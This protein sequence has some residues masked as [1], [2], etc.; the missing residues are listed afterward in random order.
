MFPTWP[1]KSELGHRAARKH[2]ASPKAPEG[3]G[4]ASK[5]VL[6]CSFSP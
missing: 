5:V 2:N 4:A 6:F 3:G 1:A